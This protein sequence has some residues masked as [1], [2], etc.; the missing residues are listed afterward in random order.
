[1]E[2]FIREFAECDPQDPSLLRDYYL[3]TEKLHYRTDYG[4]SAGRPEE[5]GEDPADVIERVN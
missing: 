5:A 1:M 3:W 4:S 2:R